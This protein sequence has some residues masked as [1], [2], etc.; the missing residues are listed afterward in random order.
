[1]TGETHHLAF[2][3]CAYRFLL[4]I[5]PPTFR[6]EY[7]LEMGQVFQTTCLVRL[8]QRGW[9]GLVLYCLYAFIDLLLTASQE[10]W[11]VCTADP[12][13]ERSRIMLRPVDEFRPFLEEMTTAL[14][15]QPTYYPLFVTKIEALQSVN[16]VADCLAL[17]GDLADATTLFTLFQSAGEGMPPATTPRWLARL[18][19]AVRQ[20]QVDVADAPAAEVTGHLI[21]RIYADPDLFELIAAEEVGQQLVDVVESLALDGNVEEID[22]MLALMQQ[23][24]NGK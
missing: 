22:Q 23:L 24:G 21:R 5:Y 11:R 1:M 7:G 9:R 18:C 4:R 15:R 10:W 2:A 20:S 12:G 19:E 17:E 6:Q 14:E 16:T 8:Q 3:L 13:L